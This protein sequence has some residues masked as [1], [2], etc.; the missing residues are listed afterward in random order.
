[1]HRNAES[2]GQKVLPHAASYIVVQDICIVGYCGRVYYM[3]ELILWM[4]NPNVLAGSFTSAA[5]TRGDKTSLLCESL[6]YQF[7][8]SV[9][10][11]F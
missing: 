1:M 10:M 2:M 6:E 9:N 11:N 5:R 8:P 7:G 3:R 4:H